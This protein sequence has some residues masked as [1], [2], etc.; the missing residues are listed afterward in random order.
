MAPPVVRGEH[1]GA[2]LDGYLAQPAEGASNGAGLIV[3][4][5]WWGLTPDIREV[6]ERY[7]AEGYLA[8]C[9][10]LY[11]GEVADEPDE[12]RKHALMLDRESAVAEILAAVRWL[13]EEHGVRSV[14]VTGFCL[15]GSLTLEAMTRPGSGID[16]GHAYYGGGQLAAEHVATISAPVAGSYGSLDESIPAEQV[17]AI[18]AAL[19]GAGTEN[20]IVLYEGA[21]HAF[22]NPT[23]EAYHAEAAADSWRRSL[24][25]WR[26]HL[27][28]HPPGGP[29]ARPRKGA[30]DGERPTLL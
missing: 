2:L 25:W 29:R 18:R 10:D 7:A 3:I 19:E 11:H 4:Q 23:R 28:Q 12:A 26:R 21:R 15:G 24:A 22:F 30:R 5:E 14:G 1:A 16:A 6:A 8:Y 13:R 9:P 20:D 27:L 17:D